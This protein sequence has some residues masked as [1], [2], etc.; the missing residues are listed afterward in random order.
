A[1]NLILFAAMIVK[2]GISG[3]HGAQVVAG[4]EISHPGP[5]RATVA[6]E[7]I[8]REILRLL[9]DDPVLLRHA[10]GYRAARWVRQGAGHPSEPRIKAFNH[11]WTRINTNG[12]RVSELGHRGH[13]RHDDK[14]VKLG[15][16]LE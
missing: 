3:A 12:N 14:N 4:L 10:C 8:P 9:L 13:P 15:C 1:D 6:H 5:R 7:C 2:D 16:R 11:E